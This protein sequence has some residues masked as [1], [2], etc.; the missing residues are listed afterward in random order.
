MNYLLQRTVTNRD[1]SCEAENT[2]HLHGGGGGMMHLS[3]RGGRE[4]GKNGREAGR[5]GKA[6][7]ARQSKRGF[8]PGKG[9]KP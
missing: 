3:A 6:G 5:H 8:A 7:R 4:E 9:E 2:R 1:A